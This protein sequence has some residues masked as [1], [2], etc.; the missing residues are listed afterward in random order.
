MRVARQG[1]GRDV[2]DVDERLGA[3]TGYPN[4]IPLPP[5]AVIAIRD[6]LAPLGFE[7][8]FGAW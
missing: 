5:A 7:V 3:V 4:L 6:T 2:V 1:G 8:L